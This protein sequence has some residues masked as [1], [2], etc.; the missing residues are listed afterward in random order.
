[1]KGFQ[2]IKMKRTLGLLLV[3][4]LALG[5]VFSLASCKK[6]SG[7]YGLVASASPTKT[8]TITSFTEN[9]K[10]YEGYFTMEV[11]G[12]NSKFEFIYTRPSTVEEGAADVEAGKQPSTTRTLEGV[13][14]Y[15]DGM[16]STD[17]DEW[18]VGSPTGID[19]K[20]DLRPE[21]LT[22]VSVNK[23][24]TELVAQI[25]PD[26]VVKVLGVELNQSGNVKITVRTNGVNLAKI[27][28]EYTTESGAA[29]RI[30]TSYTYNPITIDFPEA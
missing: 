8:V 2:V 6:E 17:G 4:V 9:G 18:T 3:L 12:N 19:F 5:C 30:D 21:F 22:G 23:E 1:M 14:Y 7:I 13:I 27:V 26:N 11:E 25:T 15:K 20:F 28:L 16:F 24:D 29:V 10:T